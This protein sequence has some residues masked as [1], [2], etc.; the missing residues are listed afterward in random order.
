MVACVA[1]MWQV[2]GV[3]GVACMWRVWCS[4]CG[5]MWDGVC[6]G[7]WDGVC[8]VAC[9]WR[10]WCSRCCGKCDGVC[11]GRCGLVYIFNVYL[12]KGVNKKKLK[13]FFCGL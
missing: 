10:V 12:K 11:G 7:M 2:S 9:M 8:G 3:C 13:Y 4:R 6:G 1:C 5:G